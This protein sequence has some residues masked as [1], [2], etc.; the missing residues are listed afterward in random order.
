M[1]ALWNIQKAAELLG[2]S[3][4]TV[5]A[6]I[7]DRKLRPIRLG[8]RVL[9]AEEELER[10]VFESQEQVA[11]LQTNRDAVETGKVTQ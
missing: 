6:Y 7:R 8:R 2:I 1:K 3:P 10:L 4:W 11:C 9:L 5:G